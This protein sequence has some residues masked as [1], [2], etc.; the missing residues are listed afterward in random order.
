MVKSLLLCLYF[1]HRAVIT[2]IQSRNTSKYFNYGIFLLQWKMLRRLYN[3]LHISLVWTD[4][5]ELIQ[6]AAECIGC[7]EDA[8]QAFFTKVILT[9]HSRTHIN[10][11]MND[12]CN[13]FP[14]CVMILLLHMLAHSHESFLGHMNITIIYVC[15]CAFPT[16]TGQNGCNKMKW[17]LA[18]HCQRLSVTVLCVLANHSHISVVHCRVCLRQPLLTSRG[19][20]GKGNS[21]Q[22]VTFLFLLYLLIASLFS[23][24][25][26]MGISNPHVLPH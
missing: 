1:W 13:V 23:S 22:G 6:D 26:R 16:V 17:Y 7:W 25:C 19:Q 2:D 14:V 12:W 9:C 3:T 15:T 18:L 21:L 8:Q 24:W 20:R 10:N 5:L 4:V 11:N